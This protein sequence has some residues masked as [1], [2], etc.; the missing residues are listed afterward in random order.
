M[1]N[2]KFLLA[3]GR[4]RPR[5]GPRQR[6]L[7]ARAIDPKC[8]LSPG[9]VCRLRVGESSRETLSSA[10]ATGVRRCYYDRSRKVRWSEFGMHLRQGDNRGSTR[11]SSPPKP[12]QLRNLLGVDAASSASPPT[13]WLA[14]LAKRLPAR[15]SY[16]DVASHPLPAFTRRVAPGFIHAGHIA[17]PGD[18]WK[19]YFDAGNKAYQQGDFVTACSRLL[20]IPVGQCPISVPQES[21]PWLT[22]PFPMSPA[23][24]AIRAVERCTLGRCLCA[25][26]A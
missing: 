23:G 7:V 20:P 13:D 22:N 25:P 17:D 21:A 4:G 16:E 12:S 18:T 15:R 8:S 19:S 24:H 9:G 6:L 3:C 1:A 2:P 14:I 10:P 11:A 5:T 26:A